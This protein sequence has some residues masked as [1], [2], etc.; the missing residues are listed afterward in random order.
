MSSPKE[1]QL[2]DAAHQ[3]DVELVKS[4]SSDSSV[5][6]NWIGPEKGDTSLHRAC[7]FG[8]LEI[9]KVLLKHPLVD[10]NALNTGE[11]T[12]FFLACQ[13]GHVEVVSL[14]LN[15]M[16]ADINTPKNSQCTPLWIASQEGHLL[17]VQLVLVSGR[18]VNAKTKS[19]AVTAWNNKTAA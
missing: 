14:L 1:E 12:P 16:S 6:V 11:V 15:N 7:R 3:G 13:E 18:E 10:P 9:V 17:V 19:I 2:W 8:H 4:L 5:N